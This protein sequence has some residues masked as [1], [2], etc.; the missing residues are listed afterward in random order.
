MLHIAPALAIVRPPRRWGWSL[1]LTAS[2]LLPALAASLGAGS[3]G[4]P[5]LSDPVISSLRLPR[6]GAALLVGA[7]LA[8]SG[9]A[10]QALFRNPLADPGLIGTSS[11]AALAVIA[12]LAIGI[13]G[14]SLPLAAFAGGL[15]A[16]WLIMALARLAGGGMAGL[17]LMGLVVS[18]FCGAA[19]SLLLFMSDDLTLR[20]A[21]AWLAGSLSSASPSLLLTGSLAAGAGLLL[22]YAIGRDLDCLLLGE[23][24]AASLGIDVVRT[25]RLA[26]VGTA[27]ATGGAVA[28]SGIIGFIGM[29]VPNALA[30]LTGGS[31]RRLIMLS[32]WVGAL[33]LLTADTLARSIAWPVDLP[34]GIVAAFAGPPFFL[35]FYRRQTRSQ[36]HD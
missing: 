27:L 25:R 32:A 8:A 10:L 16:T 6:I 14:A 7:A 24:A 34:V 12:V 29:M 17:L 33:F 15:A 3:I 26:A 36:S 20:G 31:R 2:L 18:A 35:W 19:S 28:L 13:S 22:L 21:T 4:L 1:L 30:I 9:A 23:D 11:G 5:D